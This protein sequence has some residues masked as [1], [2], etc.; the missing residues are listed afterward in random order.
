MDTTAVAG[1]WLSNVN[2]SKALWQAQTSES[3]FPSPSLSLSLPFGRRRTVFRRSK[4]PVR[5]AY[6]LS[7]AA[8]AIC[9]CV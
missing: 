5:Y 2:L 7:G 3:V 6:V 8:V 9:L 4:A 1:L